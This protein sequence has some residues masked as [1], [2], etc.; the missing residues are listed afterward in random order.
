MH[1]S[2]VRFKDNGFLF[3]GHSNAG[4]ST[5][6]RMLEDRAEILCDDRMVARR[7]KDGFR[8]H[9]SWSHG[10][11]AVVSSSSAP[12][13]ALLFLEQSKT[14]RIIFL[15]NRKEII[16]KLLACLI[17]PLVTADWWEKM[18]RLVELIASDVPCYILQFDKSGSAVELIER[19]AEKSKDSE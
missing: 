15:D 14:N 19:M 13:T 2:G 4:K 3:V 18:L 12:L 7:W 1:S 11:I 8:I 6:A 9:G 10:D 16:R 5:M 17:K